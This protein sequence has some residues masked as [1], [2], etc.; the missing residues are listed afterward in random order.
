MRLKIQKISGYTLYALLG[1]TA[2]VA[3]L[4]FSGGEAARQADA[5]L[6]GEPPRTDA[7]LYWTYILLGIAAAACAVSVAAHFV[8]LLAAEPLAAAKSLTG[9]ALLAAVLAVSWQAGSGAPLDMPGYDGEGNDP[10]WLKTADM[11][12]YTIYT[13]MGMLVLLIA[14]N[15]LAKHFRR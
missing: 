6:P 15:G 11:L 2:A 1:V 13:L 9:A 5:Y 8:S 10:F 7:L 12:L 3:C 14:G 4:F